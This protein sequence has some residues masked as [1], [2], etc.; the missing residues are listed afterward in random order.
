[1]TPFI[2]GFQLSVVACANPRRL[3]QRPPGVVV[4]PVGKLHRAKL[5]RGGSDWTRSGSVLPTLRI[6]GT[7]SDVDTRGDVSLN[8]NGEMQSLSIIVSHQ[9]LMTLVGAQWKQMRDAAF[10]LPTR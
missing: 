3:L 9:C 1:M 5:L 4:P 8:N 6:K 7:V 10:G 2:T